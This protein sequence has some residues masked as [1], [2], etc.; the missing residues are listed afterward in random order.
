LEFGLI[1]IIRRFVKRLLI[2]AAVVGLITTG[3]TNGDSLSDAA[4]SW[5][6]IIG[7]DPD[8][9]PDLDDPETQLYIKSKAV[10]SGY[11]DKTDLDRYVL[12]AT[13]EAKKARRA[14]Q[15]APTVNPDVKY[16]VT[17]TPEAVIATTLVPVA[18]TLPMTN[19]LPAITSNRWSGDALIVSG[20]LTN[21]STVPVLIKGIDAKGFDQNQKMIARGSDFTVVHN[22]LA[23]GEVV[24]FKVA[25][26]D[27]TKQVKFVEVLP[28]GS[29]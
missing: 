14:L 10:S 18:E 17:T 26:K 11:L 16:L 23:P 7:S 6:D 28:S 19:V 9:H 29:Q 12:I 24:N 5:G 20:T 25:L 8:F 13:D 2:F 21:A 27:G 15:T 3:F 1:R 4:K 22:D